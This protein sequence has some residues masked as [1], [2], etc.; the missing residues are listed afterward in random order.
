M[1]DLD[2]KPYKVDSY[3]LSVSLG[4]S[5]PIL[6][7]PKFVSLVDS[8]PHPLVLQSSLH[9]MYQVEHQTLISDMTN[10]ALMN[11]SFYE[12]FCKSQEQVD[13]L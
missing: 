4:R 2:R 8:F 5:Y 13:I 7:V 6:L 10:G 9:R 1:E 3:V 12:H 11:R